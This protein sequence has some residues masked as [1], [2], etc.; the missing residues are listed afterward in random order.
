MSGWHERKVSPSRAP[1]TVATIL[2]F[3]TLVAPLAGP[4]SG[5]PTPLNADLTVLSDNFEGAFPGASWTVADS[6]PGNGTDTWASSGQRTYAG[7]GSV[8]ASG[9]GT[10]TLFWNAL[11]TPAQALPGDP[12]ADGFENST[13]G[14]WSVAD[15]D[16][17]HGADYWNYSTFRVHNGT[18]SMWCA[19]V[20]YN[21]EASDLNVNVH[22]YDDNM[23]AIL[24][25]PVNLAR[26]MTIN[27]TAATLNFWYFLASE[28]GFDRLDVV[29]NDTAQWQTITSYTGDSGGWQ[30]ATV[31]VPP[32]ATAIGFLFVSDSGGV[33]EGAYIDDVTLS[34]QHDEPN[35]ALHTYDISE[36][37]TMTRN[38]T[39]AQYATA[40]LEFRYWLDTDSASD[41]LSAM[42][43]S[44]G[45]WTYAVPRSGS[46]GGW[47]FSSV[48][49]P[50]N[51]T[52]IGFRFLTDGIGHR[53]GAYLDNV[54]VVGHVLSIV[55]SADVSSTQGF[56][57]ISTF[58]YTANA[59]QGLP[60]YFWMW[61]ASDGFRPFLQNASHNFTAVGNFTANLT[62]TDSAGQTCTAA[63]PTVTIVHDTTAVSVA[64]SPAAS[65]IEGGATSFAGR[66]HQ[67]HPLALNWT[68][69]PIACGSLSPP[70][71]TLVNVTTS[72]SAGGLLCTVTGSFG[73][74]SASVSFNVT[75]NV[76]RVTVTPPEA[77]V[78]EGGSV[79]FSAVDANGH[80]LNFTWSSSCG[81]LSNRTG[82]FTVFNATDGAGTVCR[83]AA[84]V[85]QG[86][87]TGIGIANVTVLQDASALSIFPTT[88]VVIEGGFVDLSAFDRFS[89][90]IS[91]NWSVSPP[92]CGNFSQ[93]TGNATR[94]SVST[95]SGGIA[96]AVTALPW[97]SVVATATVSVLH[98]TAT[99]T[100]V[101]GA[102]SLEEGF[103]T[104]YS[105]VDTYGHPYAADWTV[106][107]SACGG[108]FPTSGGVVNFS[109]LG[110]AGG[111]QCVITASVGASAWRAN[112][113]IVHGAAT[114]IVLDPVNATVPEGS[115]LVLG[116]FVADPQGHALS[117]H[118]IDWVS[119]CAVLVPSTGPS[120]NATFSSSVPGTPCI[121]HA[122]SGSL[123][124][125]ANVTIT[126]A[127][128]F[129]VIFVPPTASFAG[130]ESRELT[131]TVR[132]A[133]GRT[134]ADATV[135]WTASCGQL[136]SPT[137]AKVT[138]TAPS[139]LGGGTCT[140]TASTE[141]G[142]A[143]T[144]TGAAISTPM[145]VLL[146]IMIIVPIAV[147]AVAFL[148]W[149]KRRPPPPPKPVES[150]PV[151]E[152]KPSF[153]VD[154]R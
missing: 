122:S 114:L 150:E 34:A 143:V 80:A 125:L 140:I 1:S 47:L 119:S 144:S 133:K 12:F 72:A 129:V 2:L 75:H 38:V 108:F 20:G 148:V 115:F 18:Q 9:L 93:L 5:S 109:A 17:D 21:D 120:I 82:P 46:T 14:A 7:A 105:L 15:Y 81:N 100:L 127:G 31:G 40:T 137:G 131:A 60:P 23:S 24:S 96:C 67:G 85:V 106:S 134:V 70:S 98:D 90:P 89:R 79:P 66:D 11:G 77:N 97:S 30:Q 61:N 111:H 138:Y 50:L 76:S 83:V 36:N 91:V 95:D 29:Y 78:V 44:G 13:Y 123:S 4:A 53:E 10:Q 94:L 43:F 142:G 57:S 121:I 146:P 58:N 35:Q 87:A 52:A 63:A 103:G 110:N 153:E 68:L 88:S 136:S 151:E 101:A 8:W 71:G 152:P 128:P 37:G 147:A 39:V 64:P 154:I 86:V 126:H 25:R 28:N 45:A 141:S 27:A 130:G 124:V 118:D 42:Y 112:L 22:L 33:L 19:G 99:I 145:S 135:S 102:A 56:E 132:D 54:T 51:T 73:S 113:S 32:Q 59:S 6:D 62:V 84:T 74:V 16:P 139:D 48:A 69:S 104:T 55:C 116:A 41:T 107:P 117:G 92:G 26:L 49:I 3:A 65:V 149:R